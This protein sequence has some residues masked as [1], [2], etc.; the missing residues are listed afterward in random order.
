MDFL[1]E[2]GL[3]QSAILEEN[4][5]FRRKWTFSH[6]KVAFTKKVVP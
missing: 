3:F 5:L 2:N 1:E 4:G 6:R